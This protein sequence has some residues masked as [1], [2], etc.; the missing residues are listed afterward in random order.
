M[1]RPVLNDKGANQFRS[2]QRNRMHTQK[3]SD[4]FLQKPLLIY[5]NIYMKVVKALTFK[6]ANFRIVAYYLQSFKQLKIPKGSLYPAMK[7]SLT[8]L[9]QNE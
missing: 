3:Q 1:Y 8:T 5:V 7:L 6:F 2:D 4:A 9:S